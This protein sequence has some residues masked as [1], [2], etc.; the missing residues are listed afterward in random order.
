MR[1]VELRGENAAI[2]SCASSAAVGG[3]LSLV[4]VRCAK[5]PGTRG[6]AFALER[7]PLAGVPGRLG[8]V[9]AYF[10]L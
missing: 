7:A 4:S 9:T 3:S 10:F 1:G 6:R 5:A 2:G 8:K